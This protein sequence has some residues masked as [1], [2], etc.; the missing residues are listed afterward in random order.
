[1]MI[2]PD[3]EMANISDVGCVRAVNEDYFL[4]CEPQDEGE[5]ARRGRLF[6]V[7]DGM[8]GHN[9]GEIASRMA[10]QIVRD[11]FLRSELQ[12]PEAILIDAFFE[13]HRSILQHAR[14]GA[15]LEGMG[16]TCTAAILRGAR[17][18]VGHVGDCRLYLIRD[19]AARQLTDDHTVVGQLLRSGLIGPDQA[20]VHEN[21]NVLTSALGAD[22]SSAAA[23]FIKV[24][25][26][27]QPG[28]ILLLC[29]DGLHGLVE[30]QE[31]ESIARE[32]ELRDA[33][34]RLVSLAKTR[35]GADNITLQL[36]R[37]RESLA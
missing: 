16:T 31:M 25:T 3:V 19:G 8:G 17:L 26:L 20:R 1:M 24:P 13:S 22:S 28:D 23:D 7:A 30:A 21:R 35:G 18:T 15:E 11:V 33:A 4:Y 32:G 27:M 5:F 36:L 29:S 37:I 2:R 12:D 14:T 10:A 6:L 9:G 34:R